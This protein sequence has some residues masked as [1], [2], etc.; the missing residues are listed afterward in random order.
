MEIAP[1]S[2]ARVNN[3]GGF[4]PLYF[5]VDPALS[6]FVTGPV[7]PLLVP[8]VMLGAPAWPLVPLDRLAVL[9]DWRLCCRWYP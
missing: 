6:V 9:P 4:R 1:P 8:S 5:G 2:G 3:S 7:V